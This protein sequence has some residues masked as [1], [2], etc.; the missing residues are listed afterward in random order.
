MNK[1]SVLGW[2]MTISLGIILFLT[3]VVAESEIDKGNKENKAIRKESDSLF[4]KYASLYVKNS[5]VFDELNHLKKKDY[6]KFKKSFTRDFVIHQSDIN[7]NRQMD[8]ML[9]IG[10]RD[11]GT[12]WGRRTNCPENPHVRGR[13]W[14]GY[15]DELHLQFDEK[16]DD[17]YWA[18][19]DKEKFAIKL[20]GNCKEYY[21]VPWPEDF[22]RAK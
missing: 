5:E 22:D 19:Y 17:E 7:V 3:V 10:F 15:P 13:W 11:D 14:L 12:F 18:I 16:S 9:F 2:G 20:I 21:L 8:S 6:K 1:S 4:R